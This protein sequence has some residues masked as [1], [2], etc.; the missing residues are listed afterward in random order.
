[1]ANLV[2]RMKAHAAQCHHLVELGLMEEVCD[3]ESE[4]EGVQGALG[5]LVVRTDSD[6]ANLGHEAHATRSQSA[7]SLASSVAS[8]P[9]GQSLPEQPKRR[10]VQ[11]KLRVVRTNRDQQVAID[12]QLCRC[13]VAANIPFRIVENPEWR[14]L[15]EM[16]RPGVKIAN[17]H[18]LAGN[19]LEKL[20]D[21][22]I[23]KLKTTFN[24]RRVTLAVDGWTSPSRD[25]LLGFGVTIDSTTYLM[26]I[27]D[28]AGR[29][30]SSDVMA[31]IVLSYIDDLEN[32]Y[33]CRVVSINTDNASNMQKMRSLVLAE[34][35]RVL[36]VPCQVCKTQLPSLHQ[37]N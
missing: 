17:R 11:P 31:S 20:H 22:E 32:T 1:M 10:L 28:M 26:H 13:I 24:G 3:V 29:P 33:G 12:L 21:F 2:A 18:N 30:H 5:A 23:E 14:K 9:S 36:S 27:E 16:L 7:N 35:R 37:S 4:D 8:V 6:S 34:R 19:L 25:S 15:M